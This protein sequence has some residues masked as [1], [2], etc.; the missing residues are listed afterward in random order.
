MTERADATGWRGR[1]LAG[2]VAPVA[3]PQTYRNVLYLFLA[4]PLG[5]GY[6]FLLVFGLVLGVALAVVV[7][8]LLV[9]L[10]V[11][12]GSRFLASFERSLANRLLGTEIADPDDVDRDASGVVETAKAYL[13]AGST[14]GGLGFVA[15][16]FPVGVL[17]FV[18]L[19]SLLGTAI[20]L[21]LLPVYPGGAFNVEVA[22]WVV[23][24]SFETTTERLLAVPAGAVLGVVAVNVLNAFADANASIASS[25]LGS[26]ADAC[27]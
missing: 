3:D 19:V 25:L 11:V 8:G 17:S 10:G 9:L 1:S 15:L 23:A 24:R 13:R 27:E 22:G 7:V 5:L 20:E 26:N 21:L 18:L 4:F 12:V 2:V 14:W 6:Y 16:K